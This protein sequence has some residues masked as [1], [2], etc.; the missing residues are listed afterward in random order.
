MKRVYPVTIQS[1]AA[2]TGNYILMLYEPEGGMQ[3]PI[4]IGQNEAQSILLA[5][6]SAEVRRPLTHRLILNVMEAYGLTLKEVTVDRVVEGIFYATLR[7]TDGFNEKLI[8]SRTTD[9]VT[10][11]LL[12]D[13]PVWADERVIEETGVRV[14]KGKWPVEGRDSRGDSR[15]ALEEELRRCEEEE[16]YERA[17]E[18]MEQLKKYK[19]L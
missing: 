5:K 11:A 15:E 14:E 17:A 1:G 6:E 8:D 19:S 18:I 12:A 9:A 13:V 16:D 2:Q 4:I 3:V 7:L 10:L